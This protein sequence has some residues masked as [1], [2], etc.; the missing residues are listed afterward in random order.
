MTNP[1]LV[2]SNVIKGF[3]R[4]VNL[5]NA[6]VLVL[7]NPTNSYNVIKINKISVARNTT[8]VTTSDG[9]LWIERSNSEYKLI[10]SI[11]IS[12]F[13]DDGYDF[14]L[15]ETTIYLQEGDKLWAKN[16]LNN[17]GGFF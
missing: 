12:G 16:F 3:S 5:S 1:N 2:S 6:D 10:E 4:T 15:I 13:P 14:P 9:K 11:D 17:C 8:N 7:D